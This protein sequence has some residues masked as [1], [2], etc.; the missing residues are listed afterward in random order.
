[1]PTIKGAAPISE[2]RTISDLA[3]STYPSCRRP[4]GKERGKSEK[5]PVGTRSIFA[6]VCAEPCLWTVWFARSDVDGTLAARFRNAIQEAA[7]TLL[8]VSNLYHAAPQ[9]QLASAD[10]SLSLSAESCGYPPLSVGL[11]ERGFAIT[12]TSHSCSASAANGTS[13]ERTR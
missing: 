5:L 12:M 7:A 2:S 3:V 9:I 13:L 1:M 4:S 6:S 8:H 10:S 11:M